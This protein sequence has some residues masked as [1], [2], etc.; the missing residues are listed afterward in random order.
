MI[1]IMTQL[2]IL[3]LIYRLTDSVL[4]LGIAGFLSQLP[5]ALCLPYLCLPH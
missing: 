3:W 2:A 4:L 1:G 5:F